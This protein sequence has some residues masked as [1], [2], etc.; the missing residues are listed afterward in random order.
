MAAVRHLG[1]FDAPFWTTHEGH[2]AV[3]IA[4][5]NFVGIDAVVSIICKFYICDL[6]LKTTIHALNIWVLGDLIP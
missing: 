1:F 5:Q 2:L 3:F 6:G 4:V